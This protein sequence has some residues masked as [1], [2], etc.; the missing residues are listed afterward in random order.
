LLPFPAI[1]NNVPDIYTTGGKKYKN[2][3]KSKSRKSKKNITQRKMMHGGNIL[4]QFLTN[5]PLG[6]NYVQHIGDTQGAFLGTNM[7]NGISNNNNSITDGPLL[8]PE[9]VYIA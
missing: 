3:R 6:N 9:R 7:I 2:P 4:P 5:H 8:H 1:E